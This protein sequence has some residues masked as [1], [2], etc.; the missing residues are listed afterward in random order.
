MYK[1]SQMSS[2][3]VSTLSTLNAPIKEQ[4]LQDNTPGPVVE[5]RD[6]RNETDAQTDAQTE[7]NG[8]YTQYMSAQPP[9]HTWAYPPF[10]FPKKSRPPLCFRCNQK[11]HTTRQCKTYKVR[12][13]KFW[14]NNACNKE[15]PD[16][17]NNCSYAHGND[18]L[19]HSGPYC[20]RIIHEDGEMTVEGCGNPGHS[21]SDCNLNTN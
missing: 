15:H 14:V 3:T 7:S 4:G 19:R 17:T 13:C 10:T 2:E 21:V 8:E 11:G 12:I 5:P 6:E 9:M 20:I 1:V 18:E 16:G